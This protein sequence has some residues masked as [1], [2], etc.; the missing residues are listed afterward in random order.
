MEKSF[1]SL[2]WFLNIRW[3]ILLTKQVRII[4]SMKWM[5]VGNLF[6]S[7][8]LSSHAQPC[9]SKFAMPS[10]P[11]RRLCGGEWRATNRHKLGRWDEYVI[12]HFCGDFLGVCYRNYHVM[13]IINQTTD[14][15]RFCCG[16]IVVIHRLPVR[17]YQQQW[18]GKI[19]KVRELFASLCC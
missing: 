19:L 12:Y 15:P 7:V 14:L 5:I 13:I 18:D 3:H 10:S 8:L 2:L 1:L 17:R 11:D 4:S 6:R 9:R 16:D